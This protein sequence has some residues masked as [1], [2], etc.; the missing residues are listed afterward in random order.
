MSKVKELLAEKNKKTIFFLVCGLILLICL[1]FTVNYMNNNGGVTFGSVASETEKEAMYLS[2][3]PYEKNASNVGWGQITLDGNLEKN[4]NKG[5]IALI[6][7]GKKK[8]FLKGISAHATSTVIYNITNL[9]YDYFST[10]YGVD[11]S[12]EANGNGVKFC[13]YTSVDGINWNL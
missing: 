2:D 3:I 7:D 10:Y 4:H 13:I 1:F 5:L 8:L 11:A 6:V 12:R 9:D